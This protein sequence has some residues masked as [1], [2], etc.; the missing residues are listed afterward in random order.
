M[1]RF[2]LLFTFSTLGLL[3][4]SQQVPFYNHTIINPYIF[5]PA[6]AGASGDVNAFLVRNQRYLA[7][8]GAAI[9]N[10]L[11]IDGAFTKESKAGFGFMV[12]HQ[13]HGIQQQLSSAL[14][15]S[16]KL[17]INDE[18]DLR[19]GI[20]GGLLDNRIDIDGINV[21]QLDDPYI[22][23]LRPNATTFDMNAGLSYRWKVL[24]IGF[25]V[26]QLVGNKV[27]YDKDD[28]SRG[29]YRLSRHMMMT[30]EYDFELTKNIILKPYGLVRYVPGA[31]LQY[32]VTAHLDHARIGWASVGYKSDYSVQASVGFRILDHFRV[33]YS[34]EYL[35]GSMKNYSTGAHNELLVGFTF[36]PKRKDIIKTVEK[37]VEVERVVEV[38]KIVEDEETKRENEE[39]KKRNEELE[40]LLL[41]TMAENEQVKEE[42]E[43]LKK[44]I[45]R[46]RNQS[47]VVPEP[48][49]TV[50]PVIPEPTA[51]P[52]IPY[53][54]GYHFIEL[55]MSD[56]PDGFYVI[57]GVYSSKRNAQNVL[58]S[59]LR[60]FPGAYMVINKKNGFY[61]VVLLYTLDQDAAGILN[62]RQDTE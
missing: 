8:G 59:S 38:E 1:S 19:F 55:D 23:A 16:Y 54:K 26:P 17:K 58:S 61:Y 52:V 48:E 31:P 35:I 60:D 40:E 15:Y 3:G 57:S 41:K 51:D 30:A 45:E 12:S 14:S 46:L 34:Y 47:A 43:E 4:Y 33:G 37:V 20:T 50:K 25:A 6:M 18:N 7:F 21:M 22:M 10:Y 5:N 62:Y 42:N 49:D 2:L 36:R 44:E 39:L 13:A 24:R 27:A 9:N 11:T 56:S 32:D 53:A 29:F 28:V